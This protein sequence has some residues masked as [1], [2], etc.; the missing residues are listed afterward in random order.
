MD[1][2]VVP[3]DLVLN[4]VSMEWGNEDRHGWVLEDATLKRLGITHPPRRVRL[5]K[6]VECGAWYL[7]DWRRN[8]CSSECRAQRI[9][10]HSIRH[11]AKWSRLRR[12][13]RERCHGSCDKC[14]AKIERQRSR[15]DKLVY[16]SNKCRQAAYRQRKREAQQEAERKARREAQRQDPA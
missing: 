10:K 5:H 1:P 7:S 6:C 15:P 11:T 16:C 4:G 12:E 8:T 14:G 3:D 13:W 9:K 2:I